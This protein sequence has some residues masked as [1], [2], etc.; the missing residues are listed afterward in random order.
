MSQ[1]KL[2]VDQHTRDCI[3]LIFESHISNGKEMNDENPAP[4][5]RLNESS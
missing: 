2:T 4:I 5:D 3:N 1:G